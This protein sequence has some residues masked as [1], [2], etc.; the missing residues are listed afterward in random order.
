MNEGTH[1]VGHDEGVSGGTLRGAVAAQQ[2]L[3]ASGWLSAVRLVAMSFQQQVLQLITS[4]YPSVY[5]HRTDQKVMLE[6]P[7]RGSDMVHLF[8]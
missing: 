5:L 6:L 3:K 4:L 7:P 8:N 2:Q 1:Q